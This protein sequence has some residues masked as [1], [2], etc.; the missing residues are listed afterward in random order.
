L[1]GPYGIVIFFVST[2]IPH[3]NALEKI[4]KSTV[5]TSCFHELLP[6]RGGNICAPPRSWPV[7]LHWLE[8]KI[9]C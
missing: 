1:S 2:F 8:R 6:Y 3:E 4:H 5:H 7:E 9:S